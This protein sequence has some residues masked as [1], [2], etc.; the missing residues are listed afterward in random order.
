MSKIMAKTC[1]M[2]FGKQIPLAHCL[3]K[4]SHIVVAKDWEDN[5]SFKIKTNPTFI[6][7]SLLLKHERY[8]NDVEVVLWKFTWENSTLSFET[9]KKKC[10]TVTIPMKSNIF[11]LSIQ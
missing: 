6:T 2:E 4:V 3:T 8:S 10:A 1:H 9:L 11:I 5:S 7:L